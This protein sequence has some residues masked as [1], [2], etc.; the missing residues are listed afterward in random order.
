MTTIILATYIC[1]IRHTIMSTTDPGGIRDSPFTRT[2]LTEICHRADSTADLGELC[3]KS[4][5]LPDPLIPALPSYEPTGL[6]A[7]CAFRPMTLLSSCFPYD[8]AH[9]RR[10]PCFLRMGS[11]RAAS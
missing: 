1:G 3:H 11:P 8:T 9:W 10:F 6:P 2:D 4:Y 5:N 7:S